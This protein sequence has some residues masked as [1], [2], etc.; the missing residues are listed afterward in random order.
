MALIKKHV[1][2]SQLNMFLR[3]GEQYHQRY[4]KGKVIP[5]SGSLVRGKCCHKVTA[6]NFTQKIETKI[7]LPAETVKDAFSDEWE[8]TKYQIAW[9]EEELDGQSP[10]KVEGQYKDTGVAL[11]EIFHIEQSPIC[12][13]IKIED[14]FLVKFEEHSHNIE[15][16]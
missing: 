10:K 14:E 9:T 13:P 12:Q 1:S 11:T 16:Q 2:F 6:K 4:I 5:P 3:C 8:S 7:D 15:Q